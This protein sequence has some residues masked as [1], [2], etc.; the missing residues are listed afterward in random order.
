MLEKIALFLKLKDSGP[1]LKSQYLTVGYFIYIFSG[2]EI[3]ID[4]NF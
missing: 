2:S 3:V 1:F 4:D